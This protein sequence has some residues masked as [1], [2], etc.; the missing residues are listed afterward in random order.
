MAAVAFFLLSYSRHGVGF[1]PYHIDLDVYRIGGRVWL[2]GGNLYGRLPATRAGIRLPFTY[3]PAAAVLLSPLALMP[4]PAAGTMLTLVSIVLLAVVLGCFLRRLG[5][6][7]TRS[8][9]QLAWLLPPALFLEP[10][11]DTLTF[12]QI[13]IVLMALVT[14]DCLTEAPRWPRGALTGLAAAVKLTPAAFVVFFLLRK[15]YKAATTAAASFAATTAVGFAAAWHDSVRYWTSTVAQTGRIGN[16]AYA[17]NQ[18]VLAVLARAGLAVHTPAIITAWLALSAVAAAAACRGMRHAFAASEDCV[19]LSLNAAAV[20]VISP[21]SWSHHWVWCAPAVLTLAVAGR[22]YHARLLL[23]AA[24]AGLAVFGAAPQRWLPSGSSRELH[25]SAWQ[26]AAGSS[27]VIFAAL[28]L[29]L[30]ASQSR[31]GCR[32][33]LYG[34][35][36]LQSVRQGQWR[37]ALD[38]GRPTKTQPNGWS[39]LGLPLWVITGS[40]AYTGTVVGRGGELAALDSFLMAACGEFAVLAIEGEPGIGKT[41]LWREGVRQAG[42]RGAT[43][44]EARATEAEGGLSLAGIGDLFESLGDDTLEQLPDPQRKALSAALLRSSPPPEGV[45]ERSLAASVLSVLRKL[46]A[47]RPVVVAIDDAQWLDSA[48]ARALAFAARRVGPERVGLLVTVRSPDGIPLPSFDRAADPDRRRALRLGPLSVAAL[49][50]MIKARYGRAF[51]RPVMVRV[52][53]GCGGNPLY[54]LEIA[55]ELDRHPPDGGR[56]PLPAS[57]GQLLK[58]RVARMPAD[59]QD[60]L[61]GCAMLSRPTVELA[62]AEALESA[63]SAGIVIIGEGR[64][65]FSHPLLA[66]AVY[67]R[68]VPAERRR[69]HR[70][71]AEMVGDK[72]ERAR[73]LALGTVTADEA[74]AA[75]LEVAAALAVRRGAPEAAAELMELA[76]GLTPGAHSDALPG[77]KFSAA[78][79]WFD[80]GDLGRAQS[81]LEEAVAEGPAG[82]SRA[83]ALSLLAQLHFRR[84]SFTDAFQAA[85]R[86]R[87]E[88]A[89]LELQIRCELDLAFYAVS[90]AD[91]PSTLLHARAAAEALPADAGPALV[92]DVLAVV[93]IAEFLCGQG[94]NESQLERS[95]QLEDRTVAKAWQMQPSFIAGSIYLYTGRPEKALPILSDQYT[96]AIE[97]GAENVIPLH[98][99]YLTWGLIWH[100]DLERAGQI[101][102]SARQTAGLLGDPASEGAA[103]TAVALVHAYDGSIRAACEEAAEAIRIFQSLNWPAGTLF[104]LW[105]LGLAHSAAGQPEAVE[106]VLGPLTGLLVSSGDVDPGMAMFLSEQIEALIELG[107]LGQAQELVDWLEARAQRLDRALA[108]AVAGRCRA[109]LHA[110][111][112]DLESALTAVEGAMTQHDRIGIPVERARTLL[113]W[114]RLLRRTGRRA[115]ARWALTEALD[116]FQQIG[117][118]AWGPRVETELSR[119][120]GRTAASGGLTQTE[121]LVADLAISGLSNREIGERAFLTVKAVEANLTRIYRKLGIRSR[122]G[123]ARAVEASAS[124]TRQRHP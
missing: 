121:A 11:R 26:Q 108:L 117:A 30:A 118:A 51:P 52:A 38:C 33:L 27:Y 100:G 76:I 91:F 47:E 15:D 113:V 54:A 103:L 93:T 10:V 23:T 123:L 40:G 80:S 57:L 53:A 101:A 62:G 58:E 74:V 42:E 107:R 111:N 98:C 88:S 87:Q 1:G 86:A 79:F 65:R 124:G 64:V 25:W 105:A 106:A 19:A 68:V 37:A 50:E 66:S 59:T 116:I 4:F 102:A 17:S 32:L 84:N 77:R 85:S 67:D 14:A 44:L 109:L 2:H 71:L 56:I 90:L 36:E 69:V 61:L 31:R 82:N 112:R 6:A 60:A 97:S 9:W 55:A 20:L 104:P 120:G 89:D 5:A 28:V 92:A 46:S 16:P 73:H 18:C 63:E 96:Y 48:S 115:R 81:L 70:R 34:Q 114:G 13:N 35:R 8:P 12:G 94:L 99:M 72:E 43:V 22:R 75:Q 78:R 45:D 7:R 41:T 110:A 3:P 24:F 119:L 95:L 29:L 49:H 21:V 39:E 122:G 83:R